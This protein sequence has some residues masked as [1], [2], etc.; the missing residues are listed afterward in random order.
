VSSLKQVSWKLVTSDR[1]Y[2]KRRQVPYIWAMRGVEPVLSG[3]QL[4]F[5]NI[6]RN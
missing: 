3:V 4:K 2:I 1:K 6:G 5:D